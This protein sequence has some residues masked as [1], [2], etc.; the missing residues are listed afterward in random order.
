MVKS[1]DIRRKS[2][3]FERERERE[4]DCTARKN[5]EEQKSYF[6]ILQRMTIELIFT[7]FFC[8]FDVYL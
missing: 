2:R 7:L 8:I 3:T 4:H 1:E 6:L 5:D